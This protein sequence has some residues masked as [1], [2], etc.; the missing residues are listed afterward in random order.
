MALGYK[1]LIKIRC[2]SHFTYKK[3]Y[4]SFFVSLNSSYMFVCIIIIMAKC[5]FGGWGYISNPVSP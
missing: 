1:S 4:Q 3:I 5:S 2:V